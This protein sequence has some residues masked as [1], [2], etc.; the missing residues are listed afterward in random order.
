MVTFLV[1]QLAEQKGLRNAHGLQLKAGLASHVA[2][3]LW[4]GQVERISVETIDRIC[5]ALD[6]DPGDFIVRVREKPES[7][8]KSRVKG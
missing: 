1:R 5:E 2:G 6:C 4:K 7:K 3:R 8:R